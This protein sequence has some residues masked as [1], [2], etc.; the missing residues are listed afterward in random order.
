MRT[1]TLFEQLFFFT[2][3]VTGFHGDGRET[4][5][6]AFF[7][8]VWL[9]GGG[10]AIFLVSNKHVLERGAN[11]SFSGVAR[12]G[13]RPVLGKTS[14]LAIPRK[15][16]DQYVTG[17]P[18]AAVDVAVVNVTGV[19][20]AAGDSG[21]FFRS[22]T[23]DMAATVSK[24]TE[25]DA[26]EQVMF[27]GYPNAIFDRTNLTPIARGGRTATPIELDYA[28]EP[29]FLIDAS[30]FPG[31]SGSPVFLADQGTYRRRDGSVVVGSRFMFL[32]ILAA[33]HVRQVA[34]DVRQL[35]TSL[36]ASFDEPIDLGI[37]YK[38]SA[39]NEAVD[40]SLKRLSLPPRLVAA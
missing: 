32:G 39:V 30:V 38:A 29:A 2:A 1:E 20:Q 8:S 12:D 27:I 14:A 28:G 15:V 13:D 36:L 16:H 19:L 21:P 4:H 7:Y 25:L 18:D 35:P 5:G 9:E 34:G 11:L 10:G 40:V 22:I 31:S 3:F 17:H 23:S 26:I 24:L 33:V 6:T 37:V